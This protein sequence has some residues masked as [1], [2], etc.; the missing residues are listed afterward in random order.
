MIGLASLALLPARA[1]AANPVVYS[2][3]PTSGSYQPNN[4]VA[5]VLSFQTTTAIAGASVR[6][7]LSNADFTAFNAINSS[8]LQFVDYHPEQRDIVFICANN[9]CPPGT[10]NV[11]TITITTK[12][13]G[14]AG[15][16]L[17]PVE[18]ADPD[19]KPV[20]ADGAS[21]SYTVSSSAPANQQTNTTK[22]QQQN[23]YTVPKTGSGGTIVPTQVNDTERDQ[24][25]Q[26]STG[27]PLANQS[28]GLP[29]KD[30]KKNNR[31]TLILALGIVIGI[32]IVLVSAAALVA[33]KKIK[34]RRIKGYN[35]GVGTSSTA[36]NDIHQPPD[37]TIQVG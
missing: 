29:K 3:S 6:V 30:D 8:S 12:Q 15:V 32:G 33:L 2:L 5:L 27:T 22:K 23:T 37:S 10:Y 14:T 31:T 18:T 9:N 36:D 19:L 13:P 21:Y 1:Y 11:A 25:T 26:T 20:A 35:T 24:Q 16:A 4:A 28:N 7:N 17:V 34:D